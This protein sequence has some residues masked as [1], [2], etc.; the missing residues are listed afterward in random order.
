MNRLIKVLFFALVVKPFVLVVIGL[1][2]RG[3][4]NL[5]GQGGYVVIANHNSHLDTL[6]LMS[7]FPLSQIHKI[8]PVAAADYFLEQ[9]GFKAWFANV[10]IGILALDRQGK[11]DRNA[12]FDECHKAIH[13]GDILILF[14]EGSRGNPEE[15]SEL[16]KGIFYLVD[17]HP[18]TSII[19]VMMHG[20]GKAMP[21]GSKI[22]VPFNCD[23]IIGEPLP[24]SDSADTFLDTIIE[25]FTELSDHCLT[26]DKN[27]VLEFNQPDLV[28]KTDRL[29]IRPVV[30]EDKEDL[31]G[32]L[33]N[34][35]VAQY[36]PDGIYDE[37]KVDAWLVEQLE[38]S[39]VAYSLIE[40]KS[41]TAIGHIHFHPTFNDYTYE[42]GWVIHPDSQKKGY[43]FEAAKALMEHGFAKMNIQRIV[44]TCQPEN[45]ASYQLM[46]KL[47]MRREGHFKQCIQRSNGEWWDE[48][49]YAIL[50]TE[51]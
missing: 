2:T 33:S 27:K 19:P 6:V 22:P 40:N 7:L 51:M 34:P 48:Y 25:S 1:N 46:E 36:L 44:A 32:Y 50:K 11:S 47:G 9:G 12:L 23:C 15:F 13:N 39:P 5:S 4:E 3:R 38:T 49:F 41:G 16:K 10:C 42:I 17:Q 24:R 14:P 29:T 18:E 26:R 21:K 35:N 28:V 30:P 37:A 43:A 45:T 31:L 20:L 8:R